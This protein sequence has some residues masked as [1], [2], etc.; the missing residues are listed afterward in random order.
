M[1]DDRR[2]AFEREDEAR[3]QAL[4]DAAL[5]DYHRPP[6]PPRDALWAK[7]TAERGRAARP[8]AWWTRPWAWMP[9]AAAA[10]LVIGVGIGRDSLREDAR[11]ALEAQ[12]QADARERAAL[13][14][15]LAAI[16]VLSRS[17]TLLT[18]F[19]NAAAGSDPEQAS[20]AGELLTETRLLLDS[21]ASADPE[22]KRLLED[23]EL[24]LAQIERAAASGDPDERT[25]VTEGLE[26]QA[27]L[28]RLRARVPTGDI[29]TGV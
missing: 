19:R 14:Y 1:T 28:S 21:P 18:Q 5:P 26:R 17:E 3:F 8:R 10:A 12:G 9:A 7:I 11:R 13:I 22:L 25:L 2:P 29:P 16:P 6:A 27:L 15:R 4:L 23:L 20:W 24:T